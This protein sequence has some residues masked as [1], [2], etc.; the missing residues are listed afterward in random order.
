MRAGAERYDR[1]ASAGPMQIASS[2]SCTG[3][4]SRS[5]SEYATTASMP[6]VRHARRTRS[7]ISP[8]FAMRMRLTISGLAVRRPGAV[9]PGEVAVGLDRADLLAI[10]DGLARLHEQVHQRAVN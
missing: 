3:R 4:H 5:A 8:R 9:G 2:A 1:F 6:S 7:A 10:L